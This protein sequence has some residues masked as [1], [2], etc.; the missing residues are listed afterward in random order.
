MRKY[1]LV[2]PLVMLSAS[3]SS[4]TWKGMGH[5]V[6]KDQEARGIKDPAALAAEYDTEHYWAKVRARR[7]GRVNAWARAFDRVQDTL[8]RYLFNYSPNDPYINYPTDSTVLEET[9]KF[10]IEFLAR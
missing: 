10:T 6:D 1:L 7:D 9:G 8:D 4:F 3:C 5:G 2:V